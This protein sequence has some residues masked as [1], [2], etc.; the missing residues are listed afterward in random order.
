MTRSMRLTAE[1]VARVA[2]VVLDPGQKLLPGFRPAV[3]EDY[4]VL[5]QSILKDR[6]ADGAIWIF[7]VGSLIWKPAFEHVDRRVGLLR[8]WHR[9]F[10]LGWDYRYRGSEETPGLMLALDRGG[11]C[12][13]VAYR[14]ADENV[15]AT[16]EQLM[17]REVSMIPTAFPPRW[18]TIESKEGPVR[19]ITFPIDR[20]SGRYVG[21]LSNDEMADMLASACGMWGSM[22]D[23][24]F[25]T[26]SHLENLGIHDRHLWELQELVAE[27]LEVEAGD[28]TP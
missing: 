2:R 20:K 19:A 24:L 3:D 16:V 11:S 6:P 18:V 8:G 17:R 7:G 25:S 5:V 26:V 4:P 21:G 27:R 14:L 13:G 1:H 10:C 15:E 12:T 28:D 23:Y 22:A 9:A